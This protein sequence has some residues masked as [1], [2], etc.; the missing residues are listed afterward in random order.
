VDSGRKTAAVAGAFFIIAAVTA[1]IGLAL[2]RPVLHDPHYVLRVAGGDGRVLAGAFCEILL[3]ISVIGTAVTLYPVV[4]RQHEGLAL[5]YVA[6]RTVEAVVIVTGIIS[7]LS[8]VTLRQHL[9]GTPGAGADPGALV[10]VSRALVAVHD[11]TFLIGPGQV[12]GLNTLL[13]ATLMYRSRLVPR[14]I[15]IIGL[16]GGPLIFL[17]SLGVLAGAYPQLSL[18]GSLPAVPVAVWEMSLA[19]WL[20]AKGFR[21][22]PATG[23]QRAAGPQLAVDPDPAVCGA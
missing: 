3:A 4:R 10:T 16:A 17:S 21:R 14:A 12:I 22:S 5:G 20:I 9:A 15:A 8:V 18:A 6:G 2:H 23:P 13:L 1:V 7:L 11:W 19:V